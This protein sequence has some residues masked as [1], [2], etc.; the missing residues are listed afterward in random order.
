MKSG[1]HTYG[2]QKYAKQNFG[3]YEDPVWALNY[4]PDTS[5]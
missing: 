2:V 4:N 3:S 1:I 5:L